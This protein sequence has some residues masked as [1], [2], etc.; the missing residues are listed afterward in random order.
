MRKV[1]SALGLKA[2]VVL[3]LAIVILTIQTAFVV[4][5]S[6]TFQ[7]EQLAALRTR[8]QLLANL[9]AGAITSSVWEY[10]PNNTRDQLIALQQT[11]SEFESARVYESTGVEFV[12][13]GAREIANDSVVG[14][15]QVLNEGRE[16]AWIEVRLSKEQVFASSA[17]HLRR[18]IAT[19]ILLAVVLLGSTLLVLH[20]VT[21]PLG[22][23]TQLMLRFSQGELTGAVPYTDRRDEVGR[24]ARALEVFRGHALERRTAETALKRRSEELASLNQDLRQARDAAESANRIKSEFLAAMSHEIRT[25][26]NGVIGMV[27]LLM[28]SPLSPDQSNKL[29]TLAQSAQGLL[30][31]LNDV[32][33]ISKIEAGRLDLHVAPFAPRDLIGNL[34]TLWR[35]SAL[36]KGLVLTY[37]IS[38]DTPAA[39]LGDANRV[40]QVISN[41]LGNA[42]KFTER[43]GI[44]IGMAATAVDGR[45]CDLTISVK[46]TG[47]GISSEVQGRLFQK[48]SQADTSTTRRYGGT[49]LGLA[50]CKELTELLGGEV[51]VVSELGAGATF[52]MRIRCAITDAGNVRRPE[53]YRPGE[54]QGARVGTRK[55]KVLVVED[56]DVNQRVICALLEQAGHRYAVASDGIEAV[57][58]VQRGHFDAILMDIQMPKMDGPTATRAIRSLGGKYA[59]LPIIALTAN[60]MAGD[61]ERYLACG[62]D[63]YVSKPIDPDDLSSALCATVGE[64]VA[65][66]P[67]VAAPAA[68][69]PTA[70][71][72]Q[73]QALQQLLRSL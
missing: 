33:D 18:L 51:G 59:T 68:E 20:L 43:G 47:I 41:F 57:A 54:K 38:A 58:A 73:E 14:R 44:H 34:A 52:W 12:S 30:A 55:I 8:T 46:D 10:N 70:T 36:A 4:L 26:M 21:R 1:R 48:F 42:V 9:Y 40:S 23:M 6:R 71:T 31:I 16:I 3:A 61:R 39:V 13:V 60:A 64:D 2:K 28:N 67:T 66:I 29:A 5:E 25:P 56:N 45:H 49:G 69:R 63:E 7:Q 37:D 27:H 50:I 32:L 65:P 17:E 72:E 35:P 53:E 15:A 11:I 62:M 24:M 19:A 22:R